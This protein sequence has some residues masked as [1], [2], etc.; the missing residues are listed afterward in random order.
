MRLAYSSADEHV[1]PP[2][3]ALMSHRG[4]DE[5][6]QRQR[7]R[8]RGPGRREGSSSKG[9][10]LSLAPYLLP[11][12]SL[13][14]YLCSSVI[15][16]HTTAASNPPSLFSYLPSPF[17]PPSRP[18]RGRRIHVR[19]VRQQHLRHLLV[20]PESSVMKRRLFIILH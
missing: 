5:D 7:A 17:L 4:R 6:T 10:G 14:L 1:L 13:S 9:K 20:G 8:Q 3:L 12:I 15:Q 19:P 18:H 11:S 16:R 2:V